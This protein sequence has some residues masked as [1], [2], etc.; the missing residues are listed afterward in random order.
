MNEEIFL[1]HSEL[2]FL[3]VGDVWK[4][5]ENNAEVLIIDREKNKILNF[6]WFKS[7]AIA[8]FPIKFFCKE[9]F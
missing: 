2:V 5:G 1:V 4:L 7:H 9:S 3:G 8:S 6:I